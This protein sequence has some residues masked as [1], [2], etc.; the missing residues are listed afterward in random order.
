MFMFHF[1][2]NFRP[3]PYVARVIANH[4][5]FCFRKISLVNENGEL[6]YQSGKEQEYHRFRM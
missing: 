1:H 4:S 6:R 5:S 2:S 3:S